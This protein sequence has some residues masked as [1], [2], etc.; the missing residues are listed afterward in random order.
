MRLIHRFDVAPINRGATR[1]KRR[2]IKRNAMLA[3]QPAGAGGFSTSLFEL[4]CNGLNARGNDV[5]KP[6]VR[7][8]EPALQFLVLAALNCVFPAGPFIRAGSAAASGSRHPLHKFP[9]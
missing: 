2:E 6:Q 5:E 3:L 1:P 8:T 7:K 9:R 4:A